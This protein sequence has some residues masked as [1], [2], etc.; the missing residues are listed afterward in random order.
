MSVSY[1]ALARLMCFAV[2]PLMFLLIE[3]CIGDVHCV[4]FSN[5]NLVSLVSDYLCIASSGVRLQHEIVF[6]EC[7]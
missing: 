3:K 7:A 4:I 5:T 1:V 2:M 6:A